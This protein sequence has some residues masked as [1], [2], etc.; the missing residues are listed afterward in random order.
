VYAPGTTAPPL[1]NPT[2]AQVI[3]MSL[4]G[5]AYDAVSDIVY[6]HLLEELGVLVVAAAG[7]SGEDLD[8]TPHY[9]SGYR[10]VMAVSSVDY[11]LDDGGEPGVTFS[12]YFSN[13]GEDIGISAPGGFCWL[14]GDAFMNGTSPAQRH[15]HSAR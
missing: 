11:L 5:G 7:N 8:V 4:G 14:D 9:P 3:N 10:S 2:P 12:A 13:Y 15:L 1:I 6:T